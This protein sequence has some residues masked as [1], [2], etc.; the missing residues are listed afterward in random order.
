MRS[1]QH[2]T[3]AAKAWITCPQPQPWARLRLFCLP[4]AGGAASIFHTWPHDV[5][6]E[7]E[8]CPIQLPGREQRLAEPAVHRLVPLMQTLA[9]ILRPYLDLPYAFFGHSMGALL[10][11]ELARQLRRQYGLAPV[12]L[13]VSGHRGPQLPARDAPIHQLPYAAF[14]AA[15]RQ[16]QGTPEAVLQ[17]AELMQLMLPTLR[18]DFALCETYLYGTEAPFDCPIFAFGGLQD[19]NVRYEEISAWREQTSR[20][21]MLRMFPGGH[22]FLHSARVPLMRAVSHELVQL[23]GQPGGNSAAW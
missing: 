21:F 14:V 4:Y 23:L 17:H 9:P 22:F 20:T 8:V 2:S 19:H 7:V 5:P 16:L 13:F 6:L 12:A 11:F 1:T 18:A 15:L 3:A 10:S